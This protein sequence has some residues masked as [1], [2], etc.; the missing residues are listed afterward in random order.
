MTAPSKPG[1][2]PRRPCRPDRAGRCPTGVEV[3]RE[4]RRPG[5]TLQLLWL[6]H[7]AGHPDGYQ[8]TQFCRHYLRWARQLDVVMRQEHRAGEKLFV[9]YRGH[10]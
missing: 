6:E 4:L 7:K 8:Y 1:C 3:H 10:G 9:D 5:V 2:S